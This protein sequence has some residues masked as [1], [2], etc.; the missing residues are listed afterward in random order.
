MVFRTNWPAGYRARTMVSV[1]AVVLLW[2]TV[3][4]AGVNEDM[5]EAARTGDLPVVKG[6]IDKAADVNAKTNTG[7]TALMAASQNGHREVVQMLLDK[8]AAVNIKANDGRTALMAASQNG[9]REVEE[10][11][12]KAGAN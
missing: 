7:V 3:V 1:M 8:G 9:H 5:I 10:L 6:L 11:L 12:L 4:I 2:A